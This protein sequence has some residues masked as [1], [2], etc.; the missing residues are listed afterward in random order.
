MGYLHDGL[1]LGYHCRHYRHVNIFLDAGNSKSSPARS[2]LH[3]QI[4][5][6]RI[7]PL[8]RFVPVHLFRHHPMLPCLYPPGRPRIRIC[9][10]Q[11]RGPDLRLFRT[12]PPDLWYLGRPRTDRLPVLWLHHLC[13][14]RPHMGHLF[15]AHH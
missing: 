9:P 8:W 13:H 14:P 4:P 12:P 5:Q 3:T 15:H 7:P 11:G 6:V 1:R 10:P 2:L